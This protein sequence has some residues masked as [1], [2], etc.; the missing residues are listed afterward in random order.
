M[1]EFEV[2]IGT[3]FLVSALSAD[4][5]VP[6]ARAYEMVAIAASFSLISGSTSM[7]L[8]DTVL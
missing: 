6:Q 8:V 7:M 4:P 2:G 1:E 5:E 3:C